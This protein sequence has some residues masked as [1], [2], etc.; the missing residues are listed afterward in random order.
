MLQLSLSAVPFTDCSELLRGLDLGLFFSLSRQTADPFIA[1]FHEGRGDNHEDSNKNCKQTNAD[2]LW[3]GRPCTWVTGRSLAS[4]STSRLSRSATLQH[5]SKE[6]P[7]HLI[8]TG[9]QGTKT[10]KIAHME[11]TVMTRSTQALTHV[12]QAKKG[13]NA[14]MPRCHRKGP[15]GVL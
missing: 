12:V 13:K 7:M 9:L 10:T 11:T 2:N 3:L 15:C 8:V 6:V 1:D 14:K 5:I 4:L